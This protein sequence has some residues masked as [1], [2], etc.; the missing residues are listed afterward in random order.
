ME[1]A[2]KKFRKFK[3]LKDMEDAIIE[4]GNATDGGGTYLCS[5]PVDKEYK[6]FGQRKNQC[7]TREEEENHWREDIFNGDFKAALV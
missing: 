1:A 5:V 4:I 2:P 6:Q 7:M 3:F